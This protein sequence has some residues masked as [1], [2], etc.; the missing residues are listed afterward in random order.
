MSKFN[1]VIIDIESYLYNA[2][3]AC[4]TLQE[5]Q[6]QV[7]VYAEVFDLKLGID[8]IDRIVNGFLEQLEAREAILVIGSDTNFRKDINPSYKAHRTSK[9]LMYD[10][11]VD[12]IV[13]KYK[14]ISS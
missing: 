6:N 11:M 5:L 2:C 12:Y 4:K 13:K 9:P 10:M 8:Y 1:Y 3:V 14:V 7:G